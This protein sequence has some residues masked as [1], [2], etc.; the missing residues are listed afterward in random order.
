MRFAINRPLADRFFN[1]S[2]L[3]F[4]RGDSVFENLPDMNIPKME[5][6]QN[7][8]AKYIARDETL[9]LDLDKSAEAIKTDSIIYHSLADA[10]QVGRQEIVSGWSWV[11]YR[12]NDVYL[13]GSRWLRQRTFWSR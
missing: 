7:K 12:N 13:G 11:E 6:Y 3:R 1:E 4:I 10:M 2:D 5:L 8:A 9:R